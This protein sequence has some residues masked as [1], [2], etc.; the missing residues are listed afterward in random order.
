[1]Q[2]LAKGETMPDAGTSNAKPSPGSESDE[3]ESEEC[4]PVSMFALL[5]PAKAKSSKS[6]SAPKASPAPSSVA[7][8]LS[9]VGSSHDGHPPPR[10]FNVPASS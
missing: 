7:S 2:S 6:C 10:F 8:V 3:S 1:M 5:T 4:A 9:E